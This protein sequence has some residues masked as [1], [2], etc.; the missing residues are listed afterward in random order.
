ML[1]PF[2]TTACGSVL[3][4]L[5][6]A[7]ASSAQTP[8]RPEPVITNPNWIKKPSADDLAAVWPAEARARGVDGRAVISCEVS[9]EGTLRRCVVAAETPPGSGYGFAALALAPQFLMSPRTVN[10]APVAGGTVRIPITFKTVGPSGSTRTRAP[11]PPEGDRYVTAPRWIAAPTRAQVAAAYPARSRQR[12]EGGRVSLDCGV[13]PEGRLRD[14]RVVHQDP[15][16]SQFGRAAQALA[17]LFQMEPVRDESGAV[18]RFV[19]VRVP[20]TFSPER[21]D[22]R[23]IVKAEWGRLPDAA[24]FESLY[25]AKAKAAGAAGTVTLDCTVAVGEALSGCQVAREEPA[26][27]GFA[28]AALSLAQHFRMQ[29]WTSDG[30]PVDGARVRI[31][32]RYQAPGG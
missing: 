21:D 25:P 27:L 12:A 29:A 31:P 16:G 3:L 19:R 20:L 32:I 17:P 10:G 5:I 1:R 11:A 14:C 15:K 4:A 7:A 8:A 9:A 30:R 28:A 18:P 23:Q 22:G 13:T 2:L 26:G 6:G 24:Q